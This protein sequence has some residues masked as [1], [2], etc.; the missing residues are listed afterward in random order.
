M[1]TLSYNGSPITQR[2]TDGYVNATQMAKANDARLDH[3]LGN[4]Q[5]KEYLKALRESDLAK[6][7]TINKELIIVESVGFPAVKTTWIHPLVAK[8]FLHWIEKRNR[9]KKEKVK[10]GVLYIF[11]D[12]GNNAFKIGF[13]SCITER[14]KQHKISNPFM[15]L[16]KVY[17]GV[18]FDFEQIVR[19]Q[20]ER[21]RVKGTTEWYYGKKEV[22]NI[23]K[24]LFDDYSTKK[25]RK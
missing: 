24:L 18:T 25:Q 12:K 9:S 11:V 3:W 6:N 19:T 15:E 21:Y 7:G 8:E 17:K 4:Q 14:E 1:D 5:A 23:V 2:I 20:L 16:V 10:S 13:T 22:L